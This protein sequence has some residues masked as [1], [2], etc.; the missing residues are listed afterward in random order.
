MAG[1]NFYETMQAMAK[2]L[3][4]NRGTK[5]RYANARQGGKE[6]LC[7]SRWV[8][9]DRTRWIKQETMEYRDSLVSWL[10]SIDIVYV[11][12]FETDAEIVAYLKDRLVAAV[13]RET[14]PERIGKRVDWMANARRRWKEFMGWVHNEPE[15]HGLA[16]KMQ[17]SALKEILAYLNGESEGGSNWSHPDYGKHCEWY[18]RYVN[19]IIQ[20]AIKE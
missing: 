9:E 19:P 7:F 12:Q 13:E 4:R 17:A 18:N 11:L 5:G 20:E 15:Q 6:W 16:A 10:G 1:K 2:A 8:A 3:A 14:T